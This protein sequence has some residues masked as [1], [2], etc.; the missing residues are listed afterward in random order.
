MWKE[1]LIINATSVRMIMKIKFKLWWSNIPLKSPKGAITSH[2]NS[3]K[4]KKTTTYD[5]GNPG[6]DLR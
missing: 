2:L 6:P 3:L 1:V 4:T 5:V